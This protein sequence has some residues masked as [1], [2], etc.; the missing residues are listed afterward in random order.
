MGDAILQEWQHDIATR[1]FETYEAL[2]EAFRERVAGLV[3]RFHAGPRVFW[4]DFQRLYEAPAKV[5]GKACQAYITSNPRDCLA[6]GTPLQVLRGAWLS[7][8]RH[9]AAPPDR[10]EQAA[11]RFGLTDHL[12]QSIR[13]LSGGETVRLALA[14]AY[15]L[16]NCADRLTVASPFSW[17][18]MEHWEAFRRLAER[19]R[20][21]DTPVDLFALAGEDVMDPAPLAEAERPSPLVFALRLKGVALDLG[22]LV[23]HLHDRRITAAFAGCEERLVSPCLLCGGNGQGKSLL[24][25]AL[26]SAMPCSGEAFLSG[27]GG[28]R[29]RV[30]LLFQD[31]LNQ[32]LMRTMRQLTARQ[33]GNG[34]AE[35]YEA[36]ATRIRPQ[37]TAGG[38]GGVP[39]D[40]RR[41][42]AVPLSLLEIKMLLTAL[43]LVDNGT[44]L[45]LDEPDWG[46]SRRD[47]LAFVDAVVAVAHAHSVPVVLISHKPW[48]RRMA[49]SVCRVSKEAAAGEGAEGCLF[50]IRIHKEGR[51]P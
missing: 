4:S 11:E 16:A 17:L 30:R 40:D 18:A 36:L 24:A 8:T 50:Q 49:G 35:V 26:T 28:D 14:K 42:M 37:G 31:V 20:A 12:H 15:L 1:Y 43:R 9:T 19:Y 2:E 39:F 51:L 45:I 44:A 33:K 41:R 34:L 10:P 25:K 7:A 48:W 22:S 13:S 3:P 46:L 23:D 27:P 5:P 38:Q 47:A 32:T 21:C 29:L 6:F